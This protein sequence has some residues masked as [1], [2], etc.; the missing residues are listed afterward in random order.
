MASAKKELHRRQDQC[1]MDVLSCVSVWG[2]GGGCGSGAA[3]PPHYSGHAV[4]PTDV[5]PSG[6]LSTRLHDP[7]S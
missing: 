3:V 5:G 6:L 7:V 2:G 1:R 4:T